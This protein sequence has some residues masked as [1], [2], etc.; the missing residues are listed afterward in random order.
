MK[1][2]EILQKLVS[3]KYRYKVKMPT[4]L[5]LKLQLK[6]F[7]VVE[8]NNE[9]IFETN[10]LDKNL[11]YSDE[12]LIIKNYNN[13][14]KFIFKVRPLMI[15]YIIS[16]ILIFVISNFT[17]REILFENELEYNYNVYQDVCGHIKSIG[18]FKY[19]DDS[20]N[21]ISGELK[22]KY[23]TYSYIGLE[24]KGSKILIDIE[25]PNDY[26][27]NE[28]NNEKYSN[29]RAATDGKIV[30]I[31]VK[32]G[33]V[34]VNINQVVSKGD[35]LISGNV[36]Y[37]VNPNDLSTLVKSEGHVF[38]E[39]AKYITIGVPKKMKV[40]KY[41]NNYKKYLEIYVFNKNIF[42]TKKCYASS[43]IKK[44][45]IFELNKM[46]RLEQVYEYEKIAYENVVTKKEAYEYSINKI[47]TDFESKKVSLMEN[48]QFLKLIKENEDEEN[49]YFSYIIKC[50]ENNITIEEI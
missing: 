47:Y 18:P 5:Y 11:S 3:Y 28:E 24:K 31:E 40:E 41:T 15:I 8:N 39:Y 30:G 17:I 44:E 23:F 10:K 45:N 33:V 46:M 36:N 26:A 34:V 22:Q 20:L 42:N 37:L 25:Y 7:N 43:Y 27:Q 1:L 29:I 9:V 32:K 35:L 13:L 16:L 2:K 49:Y 19:L 4:D 14:L 38:I 48:I 21:N 6:G 50:V 12:V